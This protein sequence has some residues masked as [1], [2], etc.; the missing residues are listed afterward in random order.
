MEQVDKLWI[1]RTDTCTGQV[2]L[3]VAGRYKWP[4]L[5][6]GDVEESTICKVKVKC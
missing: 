3:H 4:N 5:A 6:N 2:K 1:A